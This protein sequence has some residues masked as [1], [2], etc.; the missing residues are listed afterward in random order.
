MLRINC[1]RKA[2]LGGNCVEGGDLGKGSLTQYVNTFLGVAGPNNGMLLKGK[3]SSCFT[4]SRYRCCV[5]FSSN[6]LLSNDVQLGQRSVTAMQ[7]M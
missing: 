3:I 7:L 5:M 1:S 2:I 4:K 6:R